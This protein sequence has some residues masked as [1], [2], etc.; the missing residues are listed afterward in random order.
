[1]KNL[2]RGK[3][4]Y[5][6]KLALKYFNYGDIRHFASKCPYNEN[7]NHD[8]GSQ[9]EKWNWKKASNFKRRNFKNKSFISKNEYSS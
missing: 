8:E 5:K 6:G 4:K 7:K 9:R 3:G 1:M 2:R